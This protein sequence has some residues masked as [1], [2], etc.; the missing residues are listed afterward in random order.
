[1]PSRTL[2]LLLLGSLLPAQT[3]ALPGLAGLPAATP[4]ARYI[5][6]SQDLDRPGVV[7]VTGKLG[8]GKE[9]KRERLED[10][11]LGAA[12]AV[13]QV[14][15]TQYFNVPVTNTITPR[16]VLFGKADKLQLLFDLQLARLPDG[17]ERRQAMTSTGAAL[18]DEMLGLFVVAPRPKGKGLELLHVIPFDAKVDKGANGELQFADSMHDFCEVNRRVHALRA[19]LDA[20]DKA[21]DP[22]AKKTALSALQEVVDQKLELRQSQN[23]GL[24]SQHVGP[25][26]VRAK[27]RLADA[28]EAAA[29]HAQP[30]AGAGKD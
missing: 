20:V 29:K 26:E 23:D 8:K 21:A 25:L 27:K 7:V 12:G 6:F 14:S 11:Q 4:Q 13:S 16:A 10:G 15:G 30:K 22:A 17:K 2:P 5:D 9:G 28:A 3:P 24:L 1:M 19:A 18:E